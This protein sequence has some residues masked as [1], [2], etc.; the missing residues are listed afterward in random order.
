MCV[1]EETYVYIQYTTPSWAYTLHAHTAHSLT[2]MLAQEHA[3]RRRD[4]AER[5]GGDNEED[6]QVTCDPGLETISDTTTPTHPFPA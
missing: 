1:Y 3:R 2:D 4:L 6:C 5:G